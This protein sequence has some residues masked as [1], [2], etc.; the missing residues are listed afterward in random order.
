M[1]ADVQSR[2][3]FVELD[4]T[5]PDWPVADGAYEVVLMSYI[6]GSVPEGVI[7][8]LYANA[9]KALKPG[10]R[11]LVH[12]FMVND[13]LDSPALGAL[14]ALQH[15][16]VNAEGLGLCPSNV[17]ARMTAAG[18][19]ETET[20]EMIGGLTKLIVAHKK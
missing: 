7:G 15:V 3:E 14:W 6:S 20:T 8:A 12:D 19:G 2:V 4:A 1:A 18:F 10:G 17:T 9:Y 5:S 16:T 13:S 11:L